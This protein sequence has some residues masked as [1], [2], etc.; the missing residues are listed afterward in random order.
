MSVRKPRVQVSPA[1]TTFCIY[2]SSV[3]ECEIFKVPCG[4]RKELG[5]RS[6][7]WEWLGEAP[8]LIW[9]FLFCNCT[10]HQQLDLAPWRTMG[11]FFCL[12]WKRIKFHK[13][14]H[15]FICW[16]ILLFPVTSEK[17]T[18]V[19]R[20]WWFDAWGNVQINTWLCKSGR[21]LLKKIENLFV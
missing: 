7:P 20:V 2:L 9:F 15:L 17:A 8:R 14:I 1:R 16:D 10:V 18:H 5:K 3:P 11:F 21:F 19:M 6:F 13:M 12:W 4:R